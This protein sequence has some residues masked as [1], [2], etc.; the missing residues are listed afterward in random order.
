MTTKARTRLALAALMAAAGAVAGPA[1]AATHDTTVASRASGA[2]GAK[3]NSTS[4]EPVMS[5]D[6]RYVAFLSSANNLSADG[7]DWGTDVYRRDR[8]GNVTT[9]VS[10]ATGANGAKVDPFSGAR[11]P[12]ISGDGRFVA[13]STTAT[14]V[15]PLDTDSAE[16][17]YVRDV[18]SNTT[19]LV[20]RATGASGAKSNGG[21]WEPSISGDGR[22][23]A[24][25]SGATN[26]STSVTVSR[27]QVYIRDLQANTTTLVSRAAGASGAAGGDSSRRPAISADGHKVAFYSSATN[28]SSADT[29][30]VQDLYVRDVQANT[31]TL[32]SRATGSAGAKGNGDS[33][34]ASLSADGRYVAFESVATNLS[35]ADSDALGDIFVRD[36]Q[37]NTTRL[38]S[39]ATGASGADGNGHSMLSW[40]AGGI[41]DDG[42][43]VAFVSRSTNLSPDD[44]DNEH[45]VYV[46]DLTVDTTTLVSRV[47]G[48]SGTKANGDSQQ[49]VISGNGRFVAFAS[50]ATNLN[51]VDT[52]A[53]GDV[54]VRELTAPT[55]P[56]PPP[57]P[58]PV[59]VTV[60]DVHELLKADADAAVRAAGLAPA[61]TGSTSSSAWVYRQTPAAGASVN[62]GS[63]VTL[64]M[65]TGPIN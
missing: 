58:P 16:D 40:R 61:H 26:L 31:T 34:L 57:P 54:F 44:T 4:W 5:A 39:R 13:F 19:I 25:V 11:E 64:E 60:P 55:P 9:L 21:S 38:V 30:A 7:S 28:L 51:P 52:D 1:L 49:A 48:A 3:G 24:F 10:R 8:T 41:S 65:R 35:A 36:L 18:Q 15:D 46:R 14:N 32:V 56:P 12:A 22:Y 45:D 53:L 43:R 50:W 29:D 33:D 37:S 23:V 2:G 6:G 47:Q 63:T 20:S 62:P 59:R 27:A 42:Q 17:V